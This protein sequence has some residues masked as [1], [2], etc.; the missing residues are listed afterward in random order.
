MEAEEMAMP[1][2]IVFS[3]YACSAFL[4]LFLLYQ[5]RAIHW[6]LHV[7]SVALA[8]VIGLMP[9]PAVWHVPVIELMFGAVFLFLFV[10]GICAPM[11]PGHR[12][13]HHHRPTAHHA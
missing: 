8:L 4:A 13:H 3:V 9:I 6:Y 11:F 12:G 5:F 2:A 1:T 10:W 7:L